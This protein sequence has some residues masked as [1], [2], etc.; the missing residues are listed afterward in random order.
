MKGYVTVYKNNKIIEKSNVISLH[1][2]GTLLSTFGPQ[3]DKAF[4]VRALA[5]GG[6][7]VS[8]DSADT[9]EYE[10]YDST[11]TDT[12][13]PSY[14]DPT[15]QPTPVSLIKGARTSDP[16]VDTSGSASF[17]QNYNWEDVLIIDPTD[18]NAVA[19][20]INEI[21]CQS[22]SKLTLILA[23]N[24]DFATPTGV[25]GR[26]LIVK[27]L[28]LSGLLTTT[29]SDCTAA[30]T[31]TDP[32]PNDETS[33]A[34]IPIAFEVYVNSSNVSK[35]SGEVLTLQWELFI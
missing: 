3:Y 6:Y 7:Y 26:V 33:S 23:L 19:Q 18:A 13:S 24:G 30:V 21:D 20:N 11:K 25:T 17:P 15:C 32:L 14:A 29:S 9:N 34:I 4:C 10:Y 28:L 2:G 5:V 12:V 22:G 8:T 1:G 16:Y 27:E 35:G 31:D